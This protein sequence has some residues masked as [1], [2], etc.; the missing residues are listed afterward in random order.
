MDQD[1]K[2]VMYQYFR[3]GKELFTPNEQIAQQRSDTG[4]YFIITQTIQE[5]GNKK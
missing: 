1:Q 4:E 3:E 2:S 5:E